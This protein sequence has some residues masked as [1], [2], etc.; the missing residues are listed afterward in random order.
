MRKTKIINALGTIDYH[1]GK[2][3]DR[4]SFNR[5]RSKIFMDNYYHFWDKIGH[6]IRDAVYGTDDFLE[7]L[8]SRTS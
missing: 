8:A 5:S 7:E 2:F 4:Q 6:Q 1:E 3:F